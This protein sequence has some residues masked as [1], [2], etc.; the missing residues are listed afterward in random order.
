[1]EVKPSYKHTEIGVVPHDWEV[2]PLEDFTS[3]ISYGFTN[4]MPTSESGIFMITAKDIN[5]GKIQFDTAR[6][7]T[8]EAYL[9]PERNPVNPINTERCR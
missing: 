8:K 5:H 7:T 2:L 4:P 6:C 3:F 9:V 1:M